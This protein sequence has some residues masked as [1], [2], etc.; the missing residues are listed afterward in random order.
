M[1]IPYASGS[2]IYDSKQELIISA[3]S[4]DKP[5]RTAHTQKKKKKKKASD[6][7]PALWSSMANPTTSIV[8]AYWQSKYSVV[9][10]NRWSNVTLQ[11]HVYTAYK[12]TPSEK[13]VAHS[14]EIK[15]ATCW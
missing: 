1:A 5:T 9:N 3:I 15:D 11:A 13:T 6:M 14:I 8:V 7:R 2:N 4:L 12:G 10:Q